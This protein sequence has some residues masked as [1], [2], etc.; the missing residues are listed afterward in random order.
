MLAVH[1]QD[2]IH[3][4]WHHNLITFSMLYA[5]TENFILPFSHDEVV[6]GKRLAARQD[7]G[8]RVAE[9]RDAARALR[10]HVRASRARSCCSWAASSA[11]GASGTTTQPRLAPAR[12]SGARGAAALRAGSEP[13]LS[14][15]SRRCTRS[16]STRPASAGS[17]ATTTR[18]ASSRSSATR[19]IRSD[20]VVMV[21]QL[22]AGAARRSTGSA[23]PRPAA[24]PSC[25]TATPRST[26][27]AT[28][29]TA[30][31]STREPVA[32]HGFEQSLR[33]T[34]PPLGC[35]LLKRRS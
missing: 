35:L 7:A 13:A 34:V 19:A 15:A 25:S 29:A 6:H 11:S 27:A 21:V 12:R 28:S 22:H 9:V 18:T 23:C 3:R 2:P 17:T 5:Y 14:G 1:A 26:A 30:A 33:L 8:R 24:T 10:L 16:T 32:A 31:A 4:R 20:F